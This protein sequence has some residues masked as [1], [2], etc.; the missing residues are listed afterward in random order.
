[1]KRIKYFISFFLLLVA[2]IATS[3]RFVYQ[4]SVFDGTF[5]DIS[6]QY[7]QYGAE[8]AD[9][10]V[11]K[12]LKADLQENGL[13]IFYV[14]T[15]YVSDH[16][17]IKTVYG[18]E[19]AL[20][21]L[22]QQGI[23]P[24]TYQS[25]FVGEVTIIFKGF[26][27]IPNIFDIYSFHLVGSIE[28]A[29]AFKNAT[30]ADLNHDYEVESIHPFAGS[31][32]GVYSTLTL[33]WGIVFSLILLLTLYAV[34]IGRKET[35]VKLTLGCSPYQAAIR[36]SVFDAVVYLL[37]FTG[38]YLV[39]QQF[40]PVDYKL[41]Y[42]VSL[43]LAMLAVNTI[44]HLISANVSLKKHL[45]NSL[46]SKGALIVSYIVKG[47]SVLLTSIVLASNVIMIA[48]AISYIKQGDIFH[49]LQDY[50]YCYLS[51]TM[52]ARETL[53]P[54][55]TDV[56]ALWYR[57][58]STFGQ[59]SIWMSDLTPSYRYPAVLLNPAA[60]DLMLPYVSDDL[61]MQLEH[62]E[63]EK[64]YL[65]FP[66]GHS[67]PTD[68]EQAKMLSSIAFFGEDAEATPDVITCQTYTGR[69]QL[70]GIDR[71]THL[72]ASQ[73]LTNPI[74]IVDTITHTG[75]N[76]YTSLYPGQEFLF[77]I[78][79]EE[80][81]AFL[82]DEHME[83]QI[84]RTTS[85]QDLYLYNRTCMVRNIKLLSAVSAFILILEILMIR[86]LVR[87]EYTVNGMEIAI[88]KTLGYSLLARVRRLVLTSTLLIAVSTLAAMLLCHFLR[89]GNVFYVLLCGC[90]LLLLELGIIGYECIR[91]DR[92][93]VSSLLKGARG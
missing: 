75:A 89:F 4:L 13:D 78:P 23:R 57:F 16:Q 82:A 1:M 27:E 52:D 76:W 8:G 83:N 37:E 87:F 32:D 11:K 56:D 42:I 33:V 18:T 20:S 49:Q 62:L 34:V 46:N 30:D 59:T 84:V 44:I 38:L 91:M 72:Y 22:Y 9:R 6:F 70:L 47:L 17:E 55:K 45:S 31:Q 93:Q 66:E 86:F 79:Q 50:K 3:E 25:L 53:G 21:A 51:Y 77:Q 26:E 39:L 10:T 74:V 90:L 81:E 80:F 73:F 71:Q 88:K 65:F 19:G 28:Q 29:A 48:D 36:E 61:R 64:L 15:E 41:P 40:F 54:E 24:K 92:L 63:P 85:A 43:L 7:S 5:R 69:S 2:F 14:D 58:Y 68:V 12:N 67:D 60:A 35:V